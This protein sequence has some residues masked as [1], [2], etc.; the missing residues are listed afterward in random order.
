MYR[1]QNSPGGVVET[2]TGEIEVVAASDCGP[3]EDVT[4][5]VEGRWDGGREEG[6][7]GGREGGIKG[8]REGGRE[9]GRRI[10]M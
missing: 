5:A 9:G 8:G 7:E 4:I 2:E 10:G 3:V 1:D 6:R